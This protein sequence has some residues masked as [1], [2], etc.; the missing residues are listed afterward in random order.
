MR[1]SIILLVVF[2]FSGCATGPRSTAIHPP[3][4]AAT[5]VEYYGY[6]GGG[7]LIKIFEIDGT[8]A[9][10]PPLYLAPGWHRLSMLVDN[11]WDI[12]QVV[13]FEANRVYR[14]NVLKNF[15]NFTFQLIDVTSGQVCFQQPLLHLPPAPAE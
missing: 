7:M 15:R 2:L 12:E 9:P 6:Q 8:T 13:P 5:I 10:T 14:V 3:P 1:T 4:G 11:T